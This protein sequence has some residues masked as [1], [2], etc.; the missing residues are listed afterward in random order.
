MVR[1]CI[2]TNQ[3]YDRRSLIIDLYQNLINLINQ[4]K[5]ESISYRSTL[6]IVDSR[7]HLVDAF[8]HHLNIIKLKMILIEERRE[9]FL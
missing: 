1:P 3:I 5:N 4:R 2:I 9:M 8:D 7:A 6:Y